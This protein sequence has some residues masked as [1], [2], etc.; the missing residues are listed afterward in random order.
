LA[1][2]ARLTAGRRADDPCWRVSASLDGGSITLEAGTLGTLLTRATAGRQF[3]N[4]VDVALS[5]AYEHRNGVGRLYFPA[6]DMPSTNHGVAEG[7]DG[8]GIKQS[9]GR[10]AFKGLTVTGAS[11]GALPAKIQRTFNTLS[12]ID[13]ELSLVVRAR[14]LSRLPH[15]SNPEPL[16]SALGQKRAF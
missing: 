5:G 12:S 8:E 14:D 7:L 9:Y 16:M 1:V 15:G 6:F 10:L 3:A 11:C 13:R 2:L 4:G